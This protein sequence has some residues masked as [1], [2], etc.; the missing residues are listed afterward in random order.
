[1][2]IEKGCKWYFGL[3]GPMEN[4]P[5]NPTKGTFS[6]SPD[7]DIVREALQNSLDAQYDESKPVTVKFSF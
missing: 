3:E 6:S 5:T 2:N 4:G 1:M 7:I